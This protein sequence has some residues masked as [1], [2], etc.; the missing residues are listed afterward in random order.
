MEQGQ[1][2]YDSNISQTNATGTGHDD[3]ARAAAEGTPVKEAAD[4]FAAAWGTDDAV[5]LRPSNLP[6]SRPLRAWERA[7][8]SPFAR[9][10]VRFGKVWKR[11]ILNA[12]QGANPAVDML[13]VEGLAPK[14]SKG[15][16]ASLQSPTKAVKKMC[17]SNEYGIAPQVLSWDCRASPARKI[18]TRSHATEEDL[19]ALDD[20]DNEQ[21]DSNAEEDEV[22]LVEYTDEQGATLDDGDG[23]ENGQ[24]EDEESGLI[25]TAP[26]D[27][28]LMHLG[29]VI[30]QSDAH[31]EPLPLPHDRQ[32]STFESRDAVDG[33]DANTFTTSKGGVPVADP[34]LAIESGTSHAD[35]I[36]HTSPTNESHSPIRE[37]TPPAEESSLS[38]STQAVSPSK[39]SSTLAQPTKSI[40]KPTPQIQTAPLPMGFVSPVKRRVTIKERKAAAASRRRRTLPV[41]FAPANEVGEVHNGDVPLEQHTASNEPDDANDAANPVASPSVFLP[42]RILSGQDVDEGTEKKV[43]SHHKKAVFDNYDVENQDAEDEWED[44]EDAREESL[45]KMCSS[46]QNTDDVA[47]DD[48]RDLAQEDQITTLAGQHPRGSRDTSE[49]Q[50]QNGTPPTESTNKTLTQTQ[51][52]TSPTQDAFTV[53]DSPPMQLALRMSPR[54]KS[55]SPFKKSTAS[56]SQ[57]LPHFLALTPLKM[58]RRTEQGTPSSLTARS[59][60]IDGDTV[61][62]SIQSPHPPTERSASAPPE[63]P[64]YES[65]KR[66]PKPRVSD[67]TA[68]LQAFL[69]RAAES[70]SSGVRSSISRRE[71]LENRRDSD[72]IRS[73]LAS[74]QISPPEPKYVEGVLGDIDPNSPSLRR[75]SNVDMSQDLKEREKKSNLKRRLDNL[76][77]SAELLSNDFSAQDEATQ[78]PAKAS[79]RSAREKRS[80]VSPQDEASG[81][82]RI[83]L[84]ANSD[85]VV[86]KKSEAQELAQLTRNNTRKNKG[87]SVMPIPRLIKL[88]AGEKPVE[89][90]GSESVTAEETE[91]RDGRVR[92]KEVLAE[93]CEAPSEPGTDLLQLGENGDVIS[94]TSLREST[95]GEESGIEPPAPPACD[96]PSKPKSKKSRAPRTPSAPARSQKVVAPVDPIA[97]E[98]VTSEVATI[99]AEKTE[100]KAMLGSTSQRRVSRIATPAKKVQQQQEAVPPAS[101]DIQN[102]QPPPS[103]TAVTSIDSAPAAPNKQAPLK[104]KPPTSRLPA[105][106]SLSSSL[107]QGKENGGHSMLPSTIVPGIASPPKKKTMLPA[108]FGPSHKPG[109]G[110]KFDFG[111]PSQ[112][113]PQLPHPQQN[114]DSEPLGLRSPAKKGGLGRRMFAAGAEAEP[115]AGSSGVGVEHPSFLF[116]PAKKRSIRRLNG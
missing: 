109:I 101:A 77:S 104:R 62:V 48:V 91:G 16:R 67:D 80:K 107:S 7:P 19:L 21:H 114:D 115:R 51:A 45:E 88:A 2:L 93:Y 5:L 73:A 71:S 110:P 57:E 49:D 11:P 82:N 97:K 102:Q 66:Q 61:P 40:L 39:S 9:K 116:S 78:R 24:W 37:Q 79:R 18:A 63:E 58:M 112:N 74:S 113:K 50:L 33:Q 52:L 72:T 69:S 60:D 92:W 44:Y 20:E 47:S 85:P 43:L 100:R 12:Y 53:P 34:H 94:Q 26:F 6:L 31:A 17:L 83:S 55:T 14:R 95:E 105:P 75:V 23:L 28:T 59:D 32:S 3:T 90:Q 8:K 15:R 64:S 70:K 35:G 81:P 87:G 96:T 42:A 65:P 99:N 54:R 68:L 46:V 111:V 98:S 41:E 38:N 36:E 106:T 25:E 29:D 1:S 56:S 22:V 89:M 108:S 103:H 4:T 27:S 10:R 86:L 84:R 76:Q 13:P 30:D